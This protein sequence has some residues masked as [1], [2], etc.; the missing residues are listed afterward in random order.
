MTDRIHRQ[1]PRYVSLEQ[2]VV[3]SISR[4]LQYC[5]QNSVAARA[6]ALAG[7]RL[8]KQ[9]H[10]VG[11]LNHFL[12]SMWLGLLGVRHQSVRHSRAMIDQLLDGHL[13]SVHVVR[14]PLRNRVSPRKLFLISE[15]CGDDDR[16]RLGDRCNIRRIAWRETN[17]ELVV[18]K[19]VRALEQNPIATRDK[20]GSRQL[21]L[22]ERRYI[23]VDPTHDLGVAEARPLRLRGSSQRNKEKRETRNHFHDLDHHISHIIGAEKSAL[24]AEISAYAGATQAMEV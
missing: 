19:T 23:G 3:R 21:V 20:Q 13:R 24:G 7:A 15:T 11:D 16:Q 14:Q 18:G 6:V 9:R 8:E 4:A 12:S 10:F 2:L 5:R 1:W 22:P 17:A